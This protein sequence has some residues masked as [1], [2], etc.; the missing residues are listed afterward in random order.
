MPLNRTQRAP[1]PGAHTH[2]G[3]DQVMPA[4]VVQ[5]SLAAFIDVCLFFAIWSAFGATSVDFPLLYALGAAVSVDLALTALFGLTPGRLVMGIRVALPDGRPPGFARALLR[6]ALV[7]TTGVAGPLVLGLRSSSDAAPDRMWWDMASGTS[8]IRAS[9]ADA[10]EATVDGD[11]IHPR[12]A[13][14]VAICAVVGIF[15][16]GFLGLV[17][18]TGANPLAGIFA[19]SAV[20]VAGAAIVLLI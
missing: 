13:G 12:M 5:R 7:F 11:R 15:L 18:F 14:A 3:N 19:V 9:A 10:R 2:R 4:G 1:V 8:L 6:T 17:A 16:G 20:L